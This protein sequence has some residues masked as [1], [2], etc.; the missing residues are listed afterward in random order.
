MDHFSNVNVE[1]SEIY[2]E[3]DIQQNYLT[4][5]SE[6]TPFKPDEI[7]NEI[8]P[9]ENEVFVKLHNNEA[10]QNNNNFDKKISVIKDR[11]FIKANNN[12]NNISIALIKLTL[13]STE[14]LLS[15][16]FLFLFSSYM[17]FN[18][19]LIFMRINFFI[20]FIWFKRS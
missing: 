3:K 8:Y 20:N 6:L 1:F 9:H 7:N 11:N 18:K 5:K 12:N 19:N 16:L 10:N 14:I 15:K 2:S 17:K 4:G 13:L